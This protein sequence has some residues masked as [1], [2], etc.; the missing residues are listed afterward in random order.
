MNVLRSESKGHTKRSCSYKY[1]FCLDEKIII[2]LDVQ[3]CQ[4]VFI[5]HHKP[6]VHS[7]GLY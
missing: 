2:A 7:W 1:E 4:H 6:A 5:V 3:S